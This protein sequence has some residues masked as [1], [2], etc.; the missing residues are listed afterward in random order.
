MRRTLAGAAGA[1]L[2]AALLTPLPAAASAA[3]P[4][5]A[6]SLAATA[7]AA[8]AQ[9]RDVIHG[10]DAETYTAGRVIADT[11]GAGHVRYQ[12]S[13][14]GLRVYG[15]DLVV[16]T[17]PNGAFA[18]AATGLTAPLTLGVLP[19]VTAAA[20]QTAAAKAFEGRITSVGGSELFVDASTPAAPRLA[21]ETVVRGWAPDG[22]TPSVLHVLTDALT[23]TVRGSFDEVESVLGTGYSQY[24]GTVSIDTTQ[25]SVSPVVYS[26]IDPS[27]GNNKVCSM[28]NLTGGTC[29]VMTDADNIWGNGAT[30]SPQTAGVDAHFGAAKTYDYFKNVHSRCGI[31]GACAGVTS[32]VHYGSNYVNAFWDGTQMT[33]GDGSSNLRPLTA[34]DVA[35]HEMSHGVTEAL[36]GL[37]YSGE[38]GGLNEATS[39]IFGNMVEFYAGVAA[40][41]GDYLVGEKIDIFG[42]GAPLRYMY[43]PPLDGSSYGCWFSGI[44]SADP[45]YSSGVANHFYFDLAEG[46]GATA[47]GTSPICGSA[48]A[49]TGIG[50]AKA[51]KIWY[52]ALDVYF[53]TS[54]TYAQA[55]THTL[56]A[57]A[58][59]YGACSTE[60][61]AVHLAWAAV[62]VVGTDP[63]ATGPVAGSLVWLRADAGVTSS[64]GKVSN[65]ADQSGTAHHASMTVAARQPTVVSGV[66]NGKPVIRFGGSQSLALTA[67]NPSA[68]TIFVVGKNTKTTE[69]FSMI[70]G[71]GG[72]SAN[73]QLR[74]ENGTQALVY[75]S[76]GLPTATTTI[77]NTRVFHDLV[78]RYDGATL[79]VYRDGTLYSTTSGSASG[80]WAI[81]QIGAYYSSYFMQGDLA[82][83]LVYSSA[84]TD[85]ARVS[86][87]NYLKSKYALP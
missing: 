13:Y 44:G 11:S 24:S 4:T 1:V 40:D 53:V 54:E 9:H 37:V 87:Q 50:R 18:G 16:H 64:A 29:A 31:L 52:R 70:L 33:Y 30:S 60:H 38:S 32:R 21:W 43:N 14:H 86:T 17:A 15:G 39:D 85:A 75:G 47:Y 35:G 27:H 78:I 61:K 22:Q 73:N 71:P 41:P 62:N 51:E 63:C 67:I 49:V 56:A 58:D 20:A 26:L 72:D 2:L 81:N 48:A 7:A 83:L 55:R 45:H 68:F 23:G 10:T 74:W 6:P 65:W 46:T 82:E 8:L 77:G 34:L 42:T 79:K 5:G 28:S 76:N 36:A 12:R 80:G 66:V 19:K 3:A 57:A 25:T 69:S 59:L 84:L